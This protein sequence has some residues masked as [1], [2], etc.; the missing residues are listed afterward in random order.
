[1]KQTFT[2]YGGP[3]M[4]TT[5]QDYIDQA[6]IM[7]AQGHTGT[8]EALRKVAETMPEK[9]DAPKSDWYLKGDSE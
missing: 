6:A 4:L 8:A 9:L 2:R 1:M 7:E 3:E 5:K